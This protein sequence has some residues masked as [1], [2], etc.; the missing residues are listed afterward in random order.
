M[1]LCEVLQLVFD[2]LK[3][4]T[5]TPETLRVLRHQ[6]CPAGPPE[7]LCPAPEGSLN[8]VKVILTVVYG[9][10]IIRR[11]SS[12]AIILRQIPADPVSVLLLAPAERCRLP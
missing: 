3:D 4:V 2:H 10:A 8:P 11:I 1:P 9:P 6:R 12:A 5:T 7:S